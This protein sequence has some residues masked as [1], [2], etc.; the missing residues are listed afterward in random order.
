MTLDFSMD[1]IVTTEFGIG[2]KTPVMFSFVP[3]DGRVQVALRAMVRKTLKSMEQLMGEARSYYQPSEKYGSRE[4]CYLRA[5]DSMAT[6][7]RDV[8]VAEN[9]PL[10]SR[11]PSDL[12]NVTCYF[13]RLTDRS[14]RRI[15]AFR[16]AA[17][18]KGIGKKPLVHWM[19]GS[20]QFV[21][22]AVFK[23][24]EDFDLI[25]DSEVIHVLRPK[26]LETL[27]GL[28]KW[29]LDAVPENVS[30]LA[31]EIPYVDFAS[32]EE[33]ATTRIRAA[34]YLSSIRQHNLRGMDMGAL[35]ELCEST[36]V[37]VEIVNGKLSVAEGDVMGFLEVLDRRR[38][39]IELVRERPEYYRATSRQK[40]LGT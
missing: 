8:T 40:V 36:G 7:F 19:H 21:D 5:T 1:Q 28:K 35:E 24:D 14:G 11:F 18:F 20:L 2:R 32:V 23:L 39:G 17:Y 4:Y 16:R 29:I 26:S 25:I 13:V 34:G 31:R 27:G 38:Y 6:L 10:D 22:D 9:L 3:V 15:T 37:R 30:A 12:G 33:Y